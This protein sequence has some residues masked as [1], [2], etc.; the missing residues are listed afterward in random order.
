[1]LSIPFQNLTIALCLTLQV[2]ATAF[3]PCPCTDTLMVHGSREA[4]LRSMS[5]TSGTPNSCCLLCESKAETQ[6]P[7]RS[8]ST[9]RHDRLSLASVQAPILITTDTSPV[10]L[11]EFGAD[12]LPSPCAY[13]LQVFLE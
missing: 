10:S 11:A 1:M 8:V 12:V 9:D 4:S 13:E 3:V 5:G 7:M 6:H 2:T